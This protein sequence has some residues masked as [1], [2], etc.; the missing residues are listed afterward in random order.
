MADTPAKTVAYHEAAEQQTSPMISLQDLATT[1][2]LLN[3]AIKRGAYEPTELETV[4]QTFNKLQTFLQSQA[5]A[6]A[7]AQ[8]QEA[9]DPATK[10]SAKGDK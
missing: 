6:Q 4:G 9:G 7:Q 3:I 2:G 5:E 10:E 1:L 8:A